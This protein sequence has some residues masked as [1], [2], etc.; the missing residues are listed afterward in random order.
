[1]K[2]ITY[3]SSFML[4]LSLVSCQ[5]TLELTQAT[6]TKVKAGRPNLPSFYEY[7]VY[8]KVEE[9][10]VLFT[11]VVMNNTIEKKEFSVKNE[12]TKAMSMNKKSVQ[13]GTYILSYKIKENQI[14]AENDL[15]EV[16]YQQNG[17]E[18]KITTTTSFSK[19]K[20]LK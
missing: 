5:Q 19:E 15:V 12:E 1:M 18:H 13:G 10:D 17:K 3:L 7:Q 14:K 2:F 20:K 9:G 4:F 8:V 11:K 16:F 6:K